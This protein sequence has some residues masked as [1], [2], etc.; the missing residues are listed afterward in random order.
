MP[1][2][3]GG[4]ALCHGPPHGLQQVEPHGEQQGVLQQRRWWQQSQQ[5]PELPIIA[6]KAVNR[7]RR[8]IMGYPPRFE[9]GRGR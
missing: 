7:H 4:V 3:V 2:C 6:I 1:G 5:H 8:R 9:R